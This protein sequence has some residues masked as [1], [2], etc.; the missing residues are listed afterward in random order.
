MQGAQAPTDIGVKEE[1]SNN[2]K[3]KE[4]AA[5]LWTESSEYQ[6]KEA[7]GDQS[8]IHRMDSESTDPIHV[9]R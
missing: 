1:S 3:N 6:E 8:E 5:G 2:L 9:L 7:R 4:D